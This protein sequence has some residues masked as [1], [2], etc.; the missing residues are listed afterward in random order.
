MMKKFNDTNAGL[1]VFLT[2]CLSLFSCNNDNDDLPKDYVGFERTA[3]TIECNKSQSESELQIKIIA[4]DKSAED[5]TVQLITPSTPTGQ[6]AIVR[7]T[8]S[9]VTIKAGSKSATTTIKVY[10]KNMILKQQNITLSCIPQWKEG[11]ASKL[12]ILLKQK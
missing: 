1:L 10:P 5:R 3:E 11:K 4:G 6:A 8:E 9:R 2:T 7:L 12:T